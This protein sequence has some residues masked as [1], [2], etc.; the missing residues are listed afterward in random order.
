MRI[1]FED[2]RYAI[3]LLRKSPAFTIIAVLTLALGIGANTAIYTLLDQAV[4]RRLPVKDPRQ[5]ALLRYTGENK[6]YSHTRSEDDLFFSYPMYCDLRDHNSVFSGLIATAWAQVGVQWHN[7]PGLADTE[8]V[9]GNYFDVLG[10]RPAMGRLF[11]SSDNVAQNAN[12]VVVLSFSYWQRRFGSDPQILNQTV[13]INGHPFTVIGVAPPTFHSV[14]AGDS[15]ALFVP[16]MMKPQITPGWNDLDVRRSVWLNIIGRLKPGLTRQQAQAAI[17]PLWHSIRAQ[18]LSEMGRSSEHFKDAFLTHSHLFLEDGSKGVWN[19]DGTR[20]ALLVVMGMTGLMVLIACANVGCLLL[21]RVAA[22]TREISVRYALGAKRT[23]IIQQLL[24]EGLLL[25]ITGGIAGLVL[26]PQVSILLTRILWSGS[27]GEVAFSSTPD[28]RILAF[29]FL[30]TLLVSGAFSLFPAIQFWR[31]DVSPALK[32]RIAF[33]GSRL[34]LRQSMVVAQI[35]LSLLLLVGAGLFV[36]TL[37]NLKSLNVGFSTGNLITFALDPRLAGYEHSQSGDLYQRIL[38]QLA[39]LPGVHSAAATSDPELANFNTSSNVT[40]AGYRASENEKMSVETAKVSPSYFTTLQIPLIAGRDFS[41]QDRLGTPKVAVVNETF[42]RRFFGEP[43]NAIGRYFCWGAGDVT[44]DIQIIGLAK[45]SLHTSVRDG[46]RPSAFTPFLQEKDAGTKTAGMTFYVRTWQAPEAAESTIRQFIHQFD[47]RLVL[48][49]FRTMQEQ[50]DDNLTTERAIA[51]LASGFGL[52]AALMAA[53][54]IYGV[55]AYSTAQRI[56]EIGVRMALGATR[57]TVLRLVLA[58]VLWMA[59]GGIAVGMPLSFLLA[60]S[61]RSQLFGVSG[62]DPLTITTV[63][64]ALV[65][66]ALIAAAVPARRAAK[67]D[68]LVAL[69]YE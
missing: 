21:V 40:I 63:S 36:R 58:D 69:R 9:S 53:I 17:D 13:L 1:I 30:L 2:L 8:M 66:V 38:D 35:G 50:I 27:E 37:H 22:R 45:D 39:T 41:D 6:G 11:V 4:L 60:R 49:H 64:A 42:A 26:A 67:V 57:W 19:T 10:V 7:E 5:L 44:P 16:M 46:I 14:G 18:E 55:L 20:T 15:P 33:A 61:V 47:S 56:P 31:P 51:L 65:A 62:Y 3:R 25:G 52:L 59:A 68:P 12:P 34:R 29:T 54:G 24:A 48:N 32:E 28:L 23:R 43:Q